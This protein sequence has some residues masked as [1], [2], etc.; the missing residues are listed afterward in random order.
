MNG[1]DPLSSAELYDPATGTWTATGSMT[2]ARGGHTATML[3]DGK[4][5]VAGGNEDLALAELYD[6]GT[7]T[8]SA[9]G[10]MGSARYSHVA[11]LLGDGR[12]LVAGGT[13]SPSPLTSA[14]LY[15]P[16]TGTWTY[17]RSLASPYSGKALTLLPDG[18]VLVGGG[19]AALY[20]PVTRSWIATGGKVIA[21]FYGPDVLLANGGVL[22]L[23]AAKPGED[24]PT[25][26]A[27]YL[28]D[29]GT[30]SWIPAGKL[31][32]HRADFTATLLPDGKVLVAGGFDADTADT[33]A[34]LA[35]A[36][37]FDPGTWSPSPVVPATPAPSPTP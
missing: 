5:L 21:G 37:L 34:A 13:W 27:A 12:V 30:G 8:W 6:P 23:G 18:R 31:D 28:F 20:D 24:N 7:G 3:L 16:G 17:A 11:T 35:T 25:T 36:E 4:V 15:D 19:P 22:A 10:S 33:S 29:P 1:R 14:E 2:I 32:V 26:T 9:T